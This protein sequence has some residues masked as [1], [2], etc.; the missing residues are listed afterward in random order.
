M[1]ALQKKNFFL[2]TAFFKQDSSKDLKGV[3]LMKVPRNRWFSLKVFPCKIHV[4]G[5][6]LWNQML[7]Q[8]FLFYFVNLRLIWEEGTTVKKLSLEDWSVSL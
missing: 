4:L 1:M 5:Q 7:C 6:A 3:H 8:L 2:T